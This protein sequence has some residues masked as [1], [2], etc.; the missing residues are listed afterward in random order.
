[1]LIE[2]FVAKTSTLILPSRGV[3]F[4]YFL[5]YFT[6]K[7]YYLEYYT[8]WQLFEIKCSIRNDYLIKG[9]N[10]LDYIAQLKEIANRLPQSQVFNA[11]INFM[12]HIIDALGSGDLPRHRFIHF[13]LQEDQITRYLA[14]NVDPQNN[15]LEQILSDLELLNKKMADFRTYL[16]DKFGYWATITEDLMK[17]WSELFPNETYL[18]LMAGNGYLS[19]G[20]IEQGIKS[21]ATD[22]LS[23]STE[24]PTGKEQLTK[25]A[26]F[27][28]LSAIEH[29]KDEVTSVVLAWS[30]DKNDIDTK[31]LQQIRQTDLHFFVIGERYGATNSHKFWDSAEFVNDNRIDELNQKY[32]Q[33]DLVNDKIFLIK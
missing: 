4:D 2:S 25:V 1:M 15:D 33:Y 9:Q 14:N 22:D 21:I 12:Q 8:F 10:I 23:W 20:F 18:E 32:P 7:L 17:T 19:K 30:P 13:E 5:P 26:Q 27:D 24:S 3:S 6:S 11:R 28:A 29:F 16:Q 31:I